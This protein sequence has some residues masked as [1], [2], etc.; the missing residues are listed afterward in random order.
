MEAREEQSKNDSATLQQGPGSSSRNAY[1]DIF[2]FFCGKW[3]CHP[4]GG[5]QLQAE[6]KIPG[7]PS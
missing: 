5:W 3:G 6:H 7:A 2:E 4:G 1:N